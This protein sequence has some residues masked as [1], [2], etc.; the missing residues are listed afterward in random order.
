M[1]V[2]GGG[3]G[4]SPYVSS[5]C[6]FVHVSSGS[7]L[8]MV[9]KVVSLAFDLDVTTDKR[10]EKVPPKVVAIPSFMSFTCYS[11]FPSS[12]IFGPFVTYSEHSKF[13][14]RTPLVS[15]VIL[16]ALISTV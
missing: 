4:L 10:K 15:K 9:M 5:A 14:N 8:V 3:G 2:M 16:G 1:V 12:C 13:L 11:F 7:F 6:V